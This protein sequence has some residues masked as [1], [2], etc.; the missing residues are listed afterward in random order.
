MNTLDTAEKVTYAR[1]GSLLRSYRNN[2]G[3]T[4]EDVAIAIGL[5]GIDRRQ[6][7]R[8]ESGELGVSVHRLLELC[9]IIDADPS[10]LINELKRLINYAR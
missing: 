2:K 1:L 4:Q 10:E 9:K 3:L 7:G 8:M 5:E 6:V